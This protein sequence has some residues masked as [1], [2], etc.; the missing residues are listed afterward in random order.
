MTQTSGKLT[1]TEE[2]LHTDVTRERATLLQR[3]QHI[4]LRMPPTWVLCVIIG[5]IALAFNLYQLGA[6]S[7]W[8][9]ETFSVE[10]A[11]QP[12]PH[13][14]AIIFG[15]EPNMELYYLFLKGWLG[16]T[17]LFGLHATEFVVRFP[18]PIFA[19]LSSVMVFLL[20]KRFLGLTVGIVG[21]GLYLLNDLQLVYAQQTRAYSMQLLLI[22]I[23]WYALFAALTV[24]SHQK[25]WWICYVGAMTLAVYAHLFTM[26][27]LLSQLLAFAGLLI[28]P[29][30]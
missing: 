20:G 2:A 27:I 15:L 11:R 8:Y 19:A 9:D 21:A 25:R 7:L 17:A 12:L 14:L 13:M 6:P 16:L 30:P 1:Q 23:A 22:C 28:L 3:L 29:S 24:D 5:A 18:S 26:L 10:L 4:H